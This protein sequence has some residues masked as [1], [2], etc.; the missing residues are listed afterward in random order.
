M[1]LGL[2]LLVIRRFVADRPLGVER[3]FDG[4]AVTFA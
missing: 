2:S 3:R 1:I 4:T